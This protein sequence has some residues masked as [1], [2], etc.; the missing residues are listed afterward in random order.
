[1]VKDR[2]DQHL[3]RGKKVRGS[4][5]TKK[6]SIIMVTLFCLFIGCHGKQ[7]V[8][9]LTAGEKVTLG[10]ST[11]GQNQ[12]FKIA[13][14]PSSIVTCH[15]TGSS[16]ED[17]LELYAKFG[18]QPTS[19]SHDA[20]STDPSTNQKVGPFPSSTLARTLYVMVNA[21]TAFNDVELWCDLTTSITELTAGKKVT[22]SIST[23]GQ[24]RMFKIAVPPSSIVTCHTTGSTSTRGDPDLFAKFGSQPTESSHDALSESSFADEKVGPFKSSTSAR[25]LSVMV[26]AHT[27]FNDV[28]LWC[29]LTTSI[30][31]LAAGKKVTLSISTAKQNRKFKITVPQSKEITCYTTGSSTSKGDPDLYVKFSTQPTLSNYYASSRRASTVEVVGPFSAS[32]TS[33]HTLYVMVYANT[34]FSNVQF[35]C[36]MTKKTTAAGG[37][38]ESPPTPSPMSMSM[39]T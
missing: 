36:D 6:P 10:I 39:S 5:P 23:E 38:E 7:E 37:Y 21:Y 20:S 30:T 11:E 26:H 1:V 9:E 2:F 8:T 19:S 3:T 29:D 32:L 18:S 25:T 13:V 33:A 16:E 4:K 17:M 31:E 15:T 24:N 14:P 22:L 35:W 28:Q 27:A 34:A 12:M